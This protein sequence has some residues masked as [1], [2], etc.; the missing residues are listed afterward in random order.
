MASMDHGYST[1]SYQWY[2]QEDGSS[3]WT[4][5]GTSQSQSVLMNYSNTEVKVVVTRGLETAE[6]EMI[7]YC[8][9]QQKAAS[10]PQDYKLSQNYPNP[11]NPETTI[12]YQL[13]IFRRKFCNNSD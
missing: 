7:C 5:L 1:P 6:D 3:S 13:P 9:E 2:V 8:G 4:T 11:F 10:L 12:K